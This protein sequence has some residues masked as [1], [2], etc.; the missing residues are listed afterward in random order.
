MAVDFVTPACVSS[1]R[2]K[3]F[4]ICD[5]V[6]PPAKPAYI[7]HRDGRKWIAVVVNEPHFE[8][9]FTAIDHCIE[10]MIRP[11]RTP[12]NRCDGMLTFNDSVI[13]IELKEVDMDGSKWI[14]KADLQ[15]RNTIKYF[16][17]ETI[18]D[19]FRIRKAYIANSDRPKFRDSQQ[20]R[21]EK[22][23]DETGYVLR[24]ENRIIL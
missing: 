24:I 11:D 22:F 23:E 21:M 4:G 1:T 12:D 6:P 14:K 15:L 2:A 3:L 19:S 13:F 7:D 8:V 18:S 20:V 9:K 5:D 10:G 17:E 16:K